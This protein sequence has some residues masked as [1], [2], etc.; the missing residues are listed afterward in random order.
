MVLILHQ[1]ASERARQLLQ[2]TS[3]LQKKLKRS[4]MLDLS[5]R[6]K[7]S[8]ETAFSGKTKEPVSVTSSST[9]Q[10]EGSTS[11]A[12]VVRHKA[13]DVDCA[14]PQ[15]LQTLENKE[16]LLDQ[17]LQSQDQ[18]IDALFHETENPLGASGIVVEGVIRPNA[19][20]GNIQK[21]ER[22][23]RRKPQRMR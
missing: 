13:D 3:L 5:Q 1:T 9:N 4:S 8:F 21:T 12:V 20:F 11:A 19:A 18:L 23:R 22:A 2:E 15:E 7:E 10:G 17:N 6:F 14:L 16:A